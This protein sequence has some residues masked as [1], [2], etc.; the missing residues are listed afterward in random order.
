MYLL[1]GETSSEVT[2]TLLGHTEEDAEMSVEYERD[3]YWCGVSKYVM[4]VRV[5]TLSPIAKVIS[6]TYLEGK[7]RTEG[8][9]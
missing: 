1:R 9:Q 4:K 3:C 6:F 7:G 2:K 8:K 5:E